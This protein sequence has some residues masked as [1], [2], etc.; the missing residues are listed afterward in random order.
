MH[1]YELVCLIDWD[2]LLL[3]LSLSIA[4]SHV[5]VSCCARR[6]RLTFDTATRVQHNPF[7]TQQY[8]RYGLVTRLPG[9]RGRCVYVGGRGRWAVWTKPLASSEKWPSGATSVDR[10]DRRSL[11][12]LDY[13]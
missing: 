4:L 9:G 12:A 6:S 5:L 11:T 13:R 7:V 10:W 3:P 1:V 2:F 8:T